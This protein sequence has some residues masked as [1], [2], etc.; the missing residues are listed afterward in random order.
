MARGRM[1]NNSVCG[2]KKFHDLPDDTCRLLATWLISKLDVRG[3][4]YAD[5]AMVKSGIFPRRDD[6]TSEKVS[7]YLDAMEAIGLIVRFEANGDTWQYWPGFE[8]NQVGLRKDR[9]APNFPAP[10]AAGEAQEDDGN[11]RDS[12]GKDAGEMPAEEKVSEVKESKE[13][14][15]ANAG[16]AK[17]PEPP[18]PKRK[19]RREPKTPAPPAVNVFRANA[20]CY[21]P[22]AWYARVA[23]AVGEKQA[24]LDRWGEVVLAWVGHGWKPTNVSGMLE[25]FE[26]G[27][28]PGEDG[29]GV[30]RRDAPGYKRAPVVRLED[31]PDISQWDDEPIEP[32]PD[33]P[34]KVL[35]CN[36]HP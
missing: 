8:H 6:I 35:G 10:P 9:E 31:M 4:F 25:C 33:A 11:A 21:P 12:G 30:P 18:P 24:D 1:L 5:P 7:E 28:I 14:A 27:K 20:H 13:N 26:Q 2:S 36:D 3:V 29:R 34:G 19:R 17:P 32:P 22:K 16:A 15:P 23:A